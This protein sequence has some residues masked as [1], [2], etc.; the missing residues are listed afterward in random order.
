MIL[1]SL[2]SIDF[3][4]NFL[5]HQLQNRGELVDDSDDLTT[6]S[7]EEETLSKISFLK[8]RLRLQNVPSDDLSD[9]PSD[10]E[11]YRL[12]LDSISKEDHLGKRFETIEEL[13]NEDLSPSYKH[14]M[15]S[16]TSARSKGANLVVYKFYDVMHWSCCLGNNIYLNSVWCAKT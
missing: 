12:P 11:V 9:S 16:P 6:V 3:Y 8:A 7:E 5:S 4:G 10:G 14:G 1:L 13:E 2:N 15:V